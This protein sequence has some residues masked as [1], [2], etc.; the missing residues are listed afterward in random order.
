[1]EA[2]DDSKIA[3][4]LGTYKTIGTIWANFYWPT[5]DENITEYIR[6]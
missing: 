3:A 2:E 6:S 5:M 1:M 4:H